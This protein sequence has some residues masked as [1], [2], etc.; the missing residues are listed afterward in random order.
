MRNFVKTIK[1]SRSGRKGADLFPLALFALLAV[2]LLPMFLGW[3]GIFF[4]DYYEVF[5][6]LFDNARSIQQ[7]AVPLWD[8]HVFAGGRINYIPNTRIWYGP[9]Y[10]FY[11]LADLENLNSC[12]AWLIKIP[13]AVQWLIC[14]LT[15]YGLGRRAMRLSR[16]PAAFAALVYAFGGAFTGNSSDPQTMYSF[17]WIP[18]A[19]WGIVVFARDGKR[20]MGILA[21]LALSFTVTCGSDVRAIFSLITIALAVAL[22]ALILPGRPSAGRTKKLFVFGCLIFILG[23]LL[24]GPY[25]TAMQET[26]AIYRESPLVS[27]SHSASKHSSIPWNYLITL[28]V[29]DLFGTVTAGASAGLGLPE[30]RS[31]WHAEGNLTGGYWLVLVCVAGSVLFWRRSASPRSGESYGEMR[32]WWWTGLSLL[33]FSLLL[34]TGRY[35]PVYRQIIHVL[36]VFGLPYAVRWRVMEHLGLF[37]LAGISAQAVWERGDRLPRWILALLPGLTIAGVVWQMSRLGD[38]GVSAARYALANR[39]GWLIGSPGVYLFVLLAASVVLL[40]YNRRH[41]AGKA[42]LILAALESVLVGFSLFYFLSFRAPDIGDTHYQTPEETLLYRIGD[43]DFLTNQ[44][45]PS[46]GPERT[47]FY[48][49]MIDQMAVLHGGDYLMG[50]CSKPLVPRWQAAL[51]RVTEGYPYELTIEEPAA[52]FFPNMSVRYLVLDRPGGIPRDRAEMQPLAGPS[53]AGNLYAYRLKETLPR[54]FTQDR[55]VGCSEEEA[56]EELINGDLRAA[57]FIDDSNQLSVISDQSVKDSNQLS[58]ISNRTAMDGEPPPITDHRLLV[59]DYQSFHPDTDQE[60]IAHFDELQRLNT[61][62]RVR[63]PTPN[64]MAIEIEVRVPALLVT[65]DVFHPGWSVNVDGRTAV[66]YRVN[67]LQRGVFLT[68]GKHE[69]EWKF[70]PEPLIGGLSGLG[71]GVLS[72]ILLIAIP[73]RRP[74]KKVAS[75]NTR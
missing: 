32:A 34:T 44:P 52:R 19:I 48:N 71:L 36:P 57:V 61:I 43:H 13:L 14:L 5:P 4:D 41:W 17:M 12:Y 21:A 37:L 39:P 31:F 22:F 25:W 55:V 58:V 72:I 62:S 60:V 75:R 15:A 42:V 28:L 65:T 23:F 53:E 16:P 9:L 8:P 45:A 69:V 74:S 7:G 67:Y 3:L 49:S 56:V 63:F 10:P 64:R 70:F 20:L 27:F 24:S 68:A 29:P 50:M 33:V 35:S 66:P 38:H 2:F 26:L 11:V 1:I 73:F 40:V 54:A 59:T 47:T 18:L 6:R 51:T 46:T 30:V